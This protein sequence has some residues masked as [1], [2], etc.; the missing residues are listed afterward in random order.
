MRGGGNP[1]NGAGNNGA[2][3][4]PNGGGGGGANGNNGMIDINEYDQNLLDIQ[5]M[6]G[7]VTGSGYGGVDRYSYTPGH[8]GW[9]EDIELNDEFKQHYELWLQQDVFSHQIDWDSLIQPSEI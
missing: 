1:N 4:G 2:I 7:N 5:L 3:N 8:G 9:D 6:G